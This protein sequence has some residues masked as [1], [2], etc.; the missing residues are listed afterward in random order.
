MTTRAAILFVAA[1]IAGATIL[2]TSGLPFIGGLV[3]AVGSFVLLWML[4]LVLGNAGIADVFWGPGFVVAGVFYLLTQPGDPTPRGFLVVGLAVL[5]A[6][7]LA[8]HIGIRNAGAPEE[9]L[10]AGNPWCAVARL[11]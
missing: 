7:R 6:A 8:I 3:V 1:T 9:V 5:W 2:L 11:L 10:S 4:S